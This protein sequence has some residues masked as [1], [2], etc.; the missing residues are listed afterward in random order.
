M[1]EDDIYVP[2]VSIDRCEYCKST[3]IVK[4]I[5]MDQTADAGRIGLEYKTRFILHSVEPLFVDLC[6]NCGTVLRTFVDKPRR[7]WVLK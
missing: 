1:A 3:N 6:D 4:H 2:P 7:Q 5:K